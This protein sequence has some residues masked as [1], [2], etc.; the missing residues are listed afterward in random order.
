MKDYMNAR[1]YVIGK[2]GPLRF[3]V[4]LNIKHMWQITAEAEQYT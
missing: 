4:L 3:F 1:R 2:G